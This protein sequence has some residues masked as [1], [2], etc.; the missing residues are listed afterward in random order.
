[1]LS[2]ILRES[3]ADLSPAVTCMIIT[4]AAA[5]HT[6][7]NFRGAAESAGAT[8][9]GGLSVTPN[10]SGGFPPVEHSAGLPKSGDFGGSVNGAMQ[11][12]FSYGGAMIFPE[13]MSEMRYPRDFLKGMWA[14]QSFIYLVYMFYGLFMYGYQG[15]VIR[16]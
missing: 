8:L 14:A 6:A 1:M 9:N 11:A 15:K 16:P 12:V 3:R 2:I 4:M 10:A 5:A 7:P 13:F